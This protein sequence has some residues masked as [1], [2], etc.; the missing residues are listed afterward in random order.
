MAS[1]RDKLVSDVANQVLQM[2]ETRLGRI[3]QQHTAT[4][5]KSIEESNAK[6]ADRIVTKLGEKYSAV[7]NQR[8]IIESAENALRR[9]KDSLSLNQTPAPRT[10]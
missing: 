8:E 5:V 4:I 1:I 9:W 2:V 3:V 7:D 10:Q 6:L